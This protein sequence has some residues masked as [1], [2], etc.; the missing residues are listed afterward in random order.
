[1][2]FFNRLYV[3][4]LISKSLQDMIKKG[5]ITKRYKIKFNKKE[6]KYEIDV[7]PIVK[8]SVIDYIEDSEII[9]EPLKVED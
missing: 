5:E 8:P 6:Q 3:R 1:M 7:E 4:F 2:N 9:E